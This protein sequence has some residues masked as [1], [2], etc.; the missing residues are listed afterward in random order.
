M[1][2]I[3]LI[4]DLPGQILCIAACIVQFKKHKGYAYQT[5]CAISN[6]VEFFFYFGTYAFRYSNAQVTDWY[7]KYYLTAWYAAH[8]EISTMHMGFTMALF[9]S[10]VMA[11]DRLLAIPKPIQY[12]TTNHKFRQC[13]SFG[14][15]VILGVSSSIFDCFQSY[16]KEDGDHYS[17]VANEDY[18]SSSFVKISAHLRSV[19]RVLGVVALIASNVLLTYHYRKKYRNQVNLVSSNAEKEKVAR[20][21]E[22]VLVFSTLSQSILVTASVLAEGSLTLA[23]YTMPRF[24]E[25]GYTELAVSMTNIIDKISIVWEFYIWL[26]ISKHFRQTVLEFFPCVK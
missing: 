9:A 11:I 17:I 2:P 4:L 1:F 22:K 10:L 21:Q 7:L 13:I 16:V 20:K 19:L 26:L 14:G 25:C 23:M 12:K 5:F 18:T 6:G 8:F 3:H 24:F 15:C